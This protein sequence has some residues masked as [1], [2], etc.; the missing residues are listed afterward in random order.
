MQRKDDNPRPPSLA[1]APEIRPDHPL[2]EEVTSPSHVRASAPK[3]APAK[4]RPPT[5]PPASG[6]GPAAAL[7]DP[8]IGETLVGRYRLDKLVG[9]GGMGRVYRATQFPLNRPVAVKILNPEF[10]KKD[11][12]FVRRFFLEAAS[13]AR[14]SHP[15]TIT[16]FDYGEAESGELF[17]AMEYLKGRPL[18]RVISAEGPFAAERV[19]HVGMQICRALREAHTKG[20]IHRDLKPGNILL[21]E[22]G[23]DADFVKVLDFGLVKLIGTDGEPV[24]DDPLTP[25]PPNELT[26]A[27]MFL[28]SPKYMSPEQI[29]GLPL[30]ARTD[31][32]SLGVLMFHMATGKP[33]FT[34]GTSV[35][36]IY[37]HVNQPVPSFASLG[38]AVAPE[39]EDAI[40]QCL[41]KH[42]E[43]RFPSM[44][45]LLGRLKDVQRLVTGVSAATETGF[46]IDVSEF[47]GGRA[48]AV[49]TP[50]STD[51]PSASSHRPQ[52]HPT[53]GGPP[54]GSQ[55]PAPVPREAAFSDTGPIDETGSGLLL[56]QGSVKGGGMSRVAPW[57]AGLAFVLVLGVL[58]FVLTKPAGPEPGGAQPSAGLVDDDPVAEPPA[59]KG[60]RVTFNSEPAGAVVFDEHGMSLGKTPLSTA[61][62]PTRPG[63]APA[64]FLF[65][66]DGFREENRT[67][68]LEGDEMEVSVKLTGAAGEPPPP[69]EGEG[70]ED[71]YKENPY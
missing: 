39:V 46:D 21:L 60:V 44:N 69:A 68:R 12:Q 57:L 50:I 43:D 42:R 38:I 13:A 65:K 11:P 70:D 7:A 52:T 48:T 28:G 61:L 9:K 19:L 10:Q 5:P 8:R 6:S 34:G 22:E 41:A 36:V 53:R 31:I 15:N 24:P 17:I 67:L 14:L 64:H 3:E 1:D 33:P 49:P 32:Y 16:V 4:A 63:Q 55:P 25:E 26:K 71:D 45:A 62:P 66:L 23:D 40:G 2:E 58:A 27:G 37:K 51:L 54:S 35:E 30:D 59:A 18:S 47:S 56:R 20:I 29:Q